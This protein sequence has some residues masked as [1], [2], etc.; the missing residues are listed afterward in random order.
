MITIDDLFLISTWKNNIN[1]VVYD[2]ETGKVIDAQPYCFMPKE[3]REMKVCQFKHN[4]DLVEITVFNKKE[5]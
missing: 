1:I 3:V 4:G 5:K 2:L